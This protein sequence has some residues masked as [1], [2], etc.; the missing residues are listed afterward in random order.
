[1]TTRNRFKQHLLIRMECTYRLSLGGLDLQCYRCM[2]EGYCRNIQNASCFKESKEN[3]QQIWT[4]GAGEGEGP[5]KFLCM[6]HCTDLSRFGMETNRLQRFCQMQSLP[7]QSALR[8]PIS[9][10]K[11][12]RYIYIYI[13]IKYANKPVLVS[14]SFTCLKMFQQN[15]NVL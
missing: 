13:S 11:E 14:R 5:G 4:G 1:M 7:K 9:C 10:S 15:N 6:A 2:S 8:E 12:F 3:P